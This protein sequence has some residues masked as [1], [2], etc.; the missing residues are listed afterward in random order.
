MTI[1]ITKYKTGVDFNPLTGGINH[2]PASNS[3]SIPYKSGDTQSS[4][5]TTSGVHLCLINGGNLLL[6]N[7]TD[8]FSVAFGASAA[9]LTWHSRTLSLRDV[10]DVVF[11][12]NAFAKPTSGISRLKF[13]ATSGQ[14]VFQGNDANG[15]ALTLTDSSIQIFKNDN[16]LDDTDYALDLVNNRI[17]FIAGQAATLNDIVSVFV[18]TS[19]SDTTA[20]NTA[21]TASSTSATA[22]AN[23][24]TTAQRWAINPVNTSVIDAVS[25][26]D[27]T[28]F[29][30]KSYASGDNQA[31]GSAK[32]WAIGGSGTVTN[33]V[34]GSNYSA[35]YYATQGN[36]AIVAGVAS[37][38][39]TVA[40][41]INNSNNINTVANALPIITTV[42]GSIGNV[43]IV[44][45]NNTN[46]NTVAGIS[47]DVTNVAGISTDVS[48]VEN[49]KA[50]VTTVAG[51]SSDVTTLAPISANITTLAPISANITTV[52]G[53][54]ANVNTVAGNNTNINTVAGNNTNINTTATN[55]ANVNTTATN[56][57]N[58]NT[59]ANN[60]ASIL[61]FGVV[62]GTTLPSP[63]SPEGSLFYNTTDDLLYVS[64][65]VT[66][67][68]VGNA[69]PIPT[70]GIII[71]SA[72]NEA[73]SFSYNLAPDF[74]DKDDADTALTYTLFSGSLPGGCV[75]PTAGNTAF[76][77][78]ASSVSSNTNYTF[79][80]KATDSLGG[81]GVQNYQQQIDTVAPTSTGGTVAIPMGYQTLA[82]SYDV[83]TDFSFPAGSTFL[84]YSLTSGALPT[85]LSLNIATGVISGTNPALTVDTSYTFS[86]TA[87]DTDGDTTVQDYSWLISIITF[88]ATGG[89]ITTNGLYTVH[90]FTGSG[91]LTFTMSGTVEMLMVAGGG[92]GGAG[93]YAG[94]GAGGAG[95][96]G[97][98]S[99]VTVAGTAYTIA[100][101]AGG[102]Q[103]SY[104]KQKG[105]SGS[106]SEFAT[107]GFNLHVL[108]GGGGGGGCFNGNSN[109]NGQSGGS[110]GGAGASSPSIAGGQPT[111]GSSSVLSM[112]GNAGGSGHYWNW[113]TGSGGGA[114]APGSNGNVNPGGI[115]KSYS[116][117]G[118]STYYAGGGGGSDDTP[119]GYGGLGGGG[120]GAWNGS[121][122]GVAP[123]QANTGGGG[124][125]G[126]NPYSHYFSGGSGIVIISYLT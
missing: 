84:H 74:E 81:Y 66:W 31:G 65:D 54:S 18:Y 103:P 42:E 39:N 105:N 38:I 113:G 13:V 75:L 83:N 44:A 6:V 59:V 47:G 5:S 15:T 122:V 80:I 115:G 11:V 94:G 82:A 108:Y 110:G 114:G 72:L 99:S 55:I 126:G 121:G 112:Y 102:T 58:V 9:T 49:I 37:S 46:I 79:A 73:A 119:S 30:A 78:T 2:L 87:T 17:T 26:V 56:I 57:A 71:I 118:T 86:I 22:S 106:N 85:G 109:D 35:K 45:G 3:L 93:S 48:A 40:T 123:G 1:L 76:T 69:S 62:T 111:L 97:Y 90:T 20:L 53:I 63:V 19:A 125:G 51:I 8:T 34:D 77:G 36:V 32:E 116:I 107:N 61:T 21:T 91:T 12:F 28:D 101:G 52:A 96:L 98:S 14:T 27:S 16:F 64:N 60:M 29:S 67:E 120:R 92:S 4:F 41:D 10:D 68:F 100:V 43:N 7:D 25:G 88:G 23:N 70:G 117:T 104:T 124:G 24:A 50:N 89:T 95:G 33:T